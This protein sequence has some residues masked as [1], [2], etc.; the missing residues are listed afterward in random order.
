M[1]GANGGLAK[2][3]RPKANTPLEVAARYQWMMLNGGLAS[4]QRLFLQATVR[5]MPNVDNED[6]RDGGPYMVA[7]FHGTA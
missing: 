6:S 7:V 3:V 4:C 1:D 5:R 2:V